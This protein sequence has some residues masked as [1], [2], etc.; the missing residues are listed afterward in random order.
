MPL[1]PR[2]PDYRVR[3][4]SGRNPRQG[5]WR[6]SAPFNEERRGCRLISRAAPG[7]S[8]PVRLGRMR[9]TADLIL[10]QFAD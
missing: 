5:A 3:V 7:K 6:A 10:T 1:I 2:T 4:E 8:L 9:V